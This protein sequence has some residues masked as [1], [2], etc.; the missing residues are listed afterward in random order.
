[1]KNLLVPF[2]LILAAL[3]TDCGGNSNSSNNSPP[4]LVSIAVTPATDTIPVG[5]F[6]QFTATG[7]YS[8][9]STQ[10]LTST[11]SWSSSTSAV[12]SIAT[13]GLATAATIGSTTVTATSGSVS[14]NTSLTVATNSLVSLQIADGDVTIANGTSH[15]FTALG[16][17]NDGSRN[18]LTNTVTWGTSQSSIATI[19]GTGRA[20]SVNTGTTN[21][22]ASM[23][24]ISAPAVTLTVT[25]ATLT[26]ITVGP[27]TR[28]IAP[29]TQLNFTAVGTFSDASTQIITQD[30]TWA[31]SSVGVATVSNTAGSYGAAIGVGQGTT[32]ISAALMGVTGMAPLNVTNA[33]LTSITLTP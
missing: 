18:D 13:G 7:T 10:N 19:S 17:F 33:T 28:T 26:S 24:S 30:V 9:G 6:L 2:A 27:S 20:S 29:L 12:A 22:S 31:S 3:L 21:I 16:I 4:T 15:Q 32:N 23:G 11:A 14:G 1:M 25:S 8:N 5:T